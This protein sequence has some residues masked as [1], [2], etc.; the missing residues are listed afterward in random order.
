[1]KLHYQKTSNGKLDYRIS[2]DHNNPASQEHLVNTKT[3]KTKDFPGLVPAEVG[4]MSNQ[5]TGKNEKNVVLTRQDLDP[6]SKDGSATHVGSEQEMQKRIKE[7]VD[8]GKSPIIWVDSNSQPFLN[9]TGDKQAGARNDAGHFVRVTGY[10][11]GETPKLDIDN[12]W[13]K[14][15]DHNNVPAHDIYEAMNPEEL[16]RARELKNDAVKA[17]QAGHPDH[18]KELQAIQAHQEAGDYKTEG[19][20]RRAIEN[21]MK[22]IQKDWRERPPDEQDKQDTLDGLDHVIDNLKYTWS[23]EHEEE[24]KQKLLG[25]A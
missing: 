15:A 23:R 22:Q 16:G 17:R 13:G 6:P 1:M 20:H 4:E 8:Q 21:E 10:H 19:A 18:A 12:Q 9:D 25:A 3:G 5:I 11:D 24:L 2:G 14:A 7:Q